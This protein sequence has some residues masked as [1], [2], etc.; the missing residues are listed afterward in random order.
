LAVYTEEKPMIHDSH[1]PVLATA[2]SLPAQSKR[3]RRKPPA[4]LLSALV[5]IAAVASAASTAYAQRCI[6]LSASVRQNLLS[7]Q[8]TADLHLL[9]PPH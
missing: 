7:L 9:P 6:E 3:R 5:L 8:S 2:A 1:H 4:P